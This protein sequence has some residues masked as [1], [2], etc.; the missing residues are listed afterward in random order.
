MSYIYIYILTHSQDLCT[1]NSLNELV[2]CHQEKQSLWQSYAIVFFHI[3]PSEWEAEHP[4]TTYKVVPP[5]RY[6]YWFINPMK[7]SSINHL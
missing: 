3:G 6:V 7:T 5:K 2:T 4:A 1:C